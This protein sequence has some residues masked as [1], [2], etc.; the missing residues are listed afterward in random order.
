M[1]TSVETAT[2]STLEA[3]RV[4]ME[5]NSSKFETPWER[6]FAKTVLVHVDGLDPDSVTCQHLIPGPDG[7]C[8]RAD[9]AIS[10][11]GVQI[12][13]EIDGYDKTGSG[14]GAT[15]AEYLKAHQRAALLTRRGWSVIRFANSQLRQEKDRQLC[16]LA[17]EALLRQLRQTTPRPAATATATET[18]PTTGGDSPKRRW[19]L[20][21]G[22][23]QTATAMVLLVAVIVG[24]VAVRPD[25]TAVPGCPGSISWSDAKDHI[26]AWVTVAGPVVRVAEDP[27]SGT[28]FLDVG[29][30]YPNPDRFALV[31]FASHRERFPSNLSAKYD[32]ESVCVSGM[33]QTYNGVAQI[34]LTRLD[35]VSI[36]D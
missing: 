7:Q 5:A 20:P 30:G 1:E 3:W 22:R 35:Q 31:I 8:F 12:V 15:R 23:G 13:I 9:F 36:A 10:E 26:G 17:L 4:W 25:A 2:R 16:I 27:G 11:P 21:R 18:N 6:N 32:G 33:V 19:H 29:E 34:Q 28:A 14:T 24:F